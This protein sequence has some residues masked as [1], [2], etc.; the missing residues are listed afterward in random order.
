MRTLEEVPEGAT[1]WSKRE[2]ARAGGHLA[3]QRAPHLA[4]VRAAAL[5]DRGLQDLP[6]P[7]A[8]R[9][10]PRRGG[11]VPGPAGE[12]GGVQRGR[13][14]AD[15]GPGTHRPGAADA[16]RGARAAQLRLRAA[17]HH[18]LVRR[19]EHRHRQGDRQ[20][21]RPAPGRGLPRLPGRD[22]PP[23]RPRPGGPRDL[24]QPLR[25][26]SPVVQRGC[27]PTRASCCTSP[28]P[29]PPGSTRSSDGSPN[30]SGDASNAACSAPSTSSPPRSKTGSSS[31]TK[32]ARPFKWTKTADQII[33]RICRYCSR[34]SGPGRSAADATTTM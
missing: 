5:A 3:D 9:Q 29:T 21:V 11:P 16:P 19:A 33:D 6:G 34:I 31:G 4:G 27:W 14:T 1:H 30:C 17:R 32:S 18:R 7:A 10:D 2:L 13:K 8:D 28:P 25:P 20:A 23:G 15:P 12:R 26:Q 22:R 24:R